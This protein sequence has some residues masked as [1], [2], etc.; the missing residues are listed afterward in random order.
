MNTAAATFDSDSSSVW[1]AWMYCL[2]LVIA[3]GSSLFWRTL[4]ELLLIESSSAKNA[5]QVRQ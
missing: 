1:F 2:A 5:Q 4:I 3:A